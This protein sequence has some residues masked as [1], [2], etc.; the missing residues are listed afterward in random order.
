MIILGDSGWASCGGWLLSI[1]ILIYGGSLGLE[2]ALHS[3]VDEVCEVPEFVGF[4]LVLGD[5][6]DLVFEPGVVEE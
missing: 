3:E 1:I 4:V 5:L 2:I 6:L